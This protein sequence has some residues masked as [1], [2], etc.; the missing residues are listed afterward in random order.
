MGK[1]DK[2]DAAKKE[3][4]ALKQ[5]K[6]ASKG[7]K[8][9]GKADGADSDEDDIEA[10]LGEFRAR[11]E[12]K[13]A[14]TIT[15][16]D[17]P[18]PRSN[19]TM[20]AL[21]NGD[22]LMF[23]G[24]FCDGSGTVV[25][26]DMFRWNV[27]KGE[28]RQIESPNTPPPRCSHQA[29]YHNEK[30]YVFGGE[31]ATLDQF[32]HY[33]D[34]WQLDI[35]THSW[36]EL[37]PCGECPSA[38]SGHRM[39]VWRGYIVLFGGFYE[40]KRDMHWYN[41]TYIY[42]FQ[43][44]T[45]RKVQQKPLAQIPRVRS[46]HQLVLHTTED[47]MYMYGGFSKEKLAVQD[48]SRKEAHVHDDM[49][50]LD[51]R[52]VLGIVTTKASSAAD[53]ADSTE[54]VDTD[55]GASVGAGGGTK[56]CKSKK[57]KGK[58]STSDEQPAF[59]VNKAIWS[60]VSK[61][62]SPPSSRSGAVIVPYKVKA[63][64]FGG[65]YD[66]EVAGHGLRSV[67]FADMFLFDLAGGRWYEMP[68]SEGAGGASEKVP[69]HNEKDDKSSA[70]S[71]V[72]TSL[73]AATTI[74]DVGNMAEIGYVGRYFVS[75]FSSSPCPRINPSIFIRG[76]KLYI[77][78]GVTELDDIEIALDDCWCIDLNKRD[79][80]TQILPG[81]MSRFE[82]KGP[83]ETGTEGTISDAEDD[84]DE[85]EDEDEDGDGDDEGIESRA[86]RGGNKG[87]RASRGRGKGE[88][89]EE[90]E[91]EEEEELAPSKSCIAATHEN[92]QGTPAAA[93]LINAIPKP[94]SGEA[95]R[96]FYNRTTTHWLTVASAT[97]SP[98]ANGMTDKEKAKREKEIK[99]EAFSMA[100][101]GFNA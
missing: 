83:I 32:H 43:E 53:T 77:Y 20:T 10:I 68:A 91:E 87:K 48:S 44:E 99:R 11:E 39:C 52:P 23:G 6:K 95:L 93:A 26:N 88:G 31:Y 76:H 51:L 22:M 100:E 71:T 59:D 57:E 13:T 96:D 33:R 17:Q 65:V 101:V 72:L 7:D 3:A 56:A 8:K 30:L 94:L 40:Q 19:F 66:E 60:R 92:D 46:G 98:I 16:V 27:E 62:G 75:R 24:E 61:K 1:K 28:W 64:L 73:L 58:G 41:D 70:P 38:R 5:A 89:G 74:D 97:A 86:K 45:W 37:A 50:M 42:S 54:T 12:R 69:A 82:W 4:R 90:S 78:G 18:S 9:E 15:T 85:G 79:S 80:W 36:T 35:K 25:Y 55:T 63:I 34:M 84:A 2:K 47:C 49:W 14:V 29:V 81:T 67:F 21:P